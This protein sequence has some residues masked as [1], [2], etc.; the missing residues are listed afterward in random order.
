[1][2]CTQP[3]GGRAAGNADSHLTDSRAMKGQPLG[4]ANS[5]HWK[6]NI[7][8]TLT[9]LTAAELPEPTLALKVME[10]G[11]SQATAYI[12]FKKI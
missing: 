4:A 6:Q 7:Q 1:M 12:K 9:E 5:P 10:S 11:F 2:H 3:E 8:G